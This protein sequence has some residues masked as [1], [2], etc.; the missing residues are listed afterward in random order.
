M[1]IKTKEQLIEELQKQKEQIHKLQKAES[2]RK[3]AEK[4]Q[5]TLYNIANAANTTS[6]LDELFKNI[7]Q[8]LGK[9]IDTTNFFI[10]LCDEKS[11]IV[12][13]PYYID[14]V[15]PDAADVKQVAQFFHQQGWKKTKMK[16]HLPAS[17]R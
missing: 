1:K 10:A 3:K 15:K 13:M 16:N 6:N 12:S 2:K 9:I 14:Q 5:A 7:H 11:D 4:T 17:Y 8:E